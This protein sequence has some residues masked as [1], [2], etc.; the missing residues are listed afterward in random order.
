[1]HPGIYNGISSADYHSGP[2]ISKSGLDLIAKSPVTYAHAIDFPASREPTPAQMFGTLL[3]ALVLEPEQFDSQYVVGEKHDRRTKEGK[4]AAAAFEERHAGKTIIDQETFD[5]AQHARDA[6]FTHPDASQWFTGGIAELSCYWNEDIEGGDP[7][8]C[9]ARPDY[10]RADGVIVD[11]KSTSPGGAA[12][13]PFGRSVADWRY[14]VQDG[15]YLHGAAKAYAESGGG[16]L[17]EKLGYRPPR[18]F[19]FVAVENDARVVRGI[20]KGVATYMLH[21]LHADLGLQIA[22]RDLQTYARCVRE[23]RFEGYS[24][25][26][27]LLELP[28]WELSKNASLIGA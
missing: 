5:R 21:R 13:A 19:V 8:L 20:A 15:F 26:I 9:R 4:I 1:M 25:R 23:N 7:I 18:S 10:W 3:H 14:H 27:E 6:V 24:P 12:E 28:T 11:L 2:G 17:L 22:M 16:Y